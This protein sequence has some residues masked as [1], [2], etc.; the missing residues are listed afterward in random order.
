MLLFNILSNARQSALLLGA[1]ATAALGFALV[2]EHVYG[3]APCI[4]CVYQRIPYAL[5]IG[6][7]LGVAVMGKRNAF[8][9]LAILAVLFFA[10][11]VLGVFHTG[12]EQ[13]WWEGTASCGVPK[14]DA[15]D[16][17]TL[18]QQILATPTARCDQAAW[19]FLGLSMATWNAFLSFLLAAL[20][21]NAARRAFRRLKKEAPEV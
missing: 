4:L 17:E 18:R 8:P 2:M 13:K 11:G 12:V 14:L 6:V 3:L 10:G 21:L 20:S 7:A 9:A 16:L 19:V 5:A 15:S 1:A